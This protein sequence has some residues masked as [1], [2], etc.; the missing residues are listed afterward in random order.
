[1]RTCHIGQNLFHR[2]YGRLNGLQ[3][4]TRALNGHELRC[5]LAFLQV[6]QFVILADPGNLV[7]LAPKPNHHVT[8]NV[9]MTRHIPQ[10]AS[11]NLHRTARLDPATALSLQGNHTIHAGKLLLKCLARKPFGHITRHGIRAVHIGN[12]RD[13][14]TRPG[15]SSRTRIALKSAAH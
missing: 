8:G 14:I 6:I 1:M 2:L 3:G 15:P 12:Y 9:R 11:N 4:T 5:Y 10:R 13:I 7:V